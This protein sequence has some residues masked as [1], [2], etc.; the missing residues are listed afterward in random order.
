MVD[1]VVEIL[2]YL[3]LL[4][5]EALINYKLLFILLFSQPKRKELF[6]CNGLFSE[7]K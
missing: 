3:D 2:M 4:Q 5:P 1:L 6:L 7:Q